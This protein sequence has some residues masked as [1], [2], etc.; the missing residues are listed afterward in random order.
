[1]ATVGENDRYSESR[2]RA[3]DGNFPPRTGRGGVQTRPGRGEWE[4]NDS[5]SFPSGL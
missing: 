2:S 5:T 1:M 4:K 3:P